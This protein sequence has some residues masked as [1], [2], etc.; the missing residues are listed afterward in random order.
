MTNQGN[1]RESGM[2]KQD[3]RNQLQTLKAT[4]KGSADN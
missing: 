4:L 3:P 2:L 1:L